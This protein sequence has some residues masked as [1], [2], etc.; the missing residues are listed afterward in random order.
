M[1]REYF[2][3]NNIDKIGKFYVHYG[4]IYDHPNDSLKRAVFKF[5]KRKNNNYYIPGYKTYNNK[6]HRCPITSNF[7]QINY[8]VEYK[9][10]DEKI[11]EA[12]LII[13]SKD[14]SEHRKINVKLKSKNS[15]RPVDIMDINNIVNTINEYAS[16]ENNIFDLDESYFQNKF[17]IKKLELYDLAEIINSLNFEWKSERIYRFKSDDLVCQ[18]YIIDDLPKSQYLISLFIQIIKESR[19]VDRVELQY[20]K[21]RTKIYSEDFGLKIPEQITEILKLKILALFDPITE[22]NERIKKCPKI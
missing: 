3:I 18:E 19:I 8:I 11:L 1:N 21:I 10:V 16:Y 14:F 4:S 6:F 22:K 20:G 12:E 2:L 17:T 15:F 5:L 13:F 9:T 7:V